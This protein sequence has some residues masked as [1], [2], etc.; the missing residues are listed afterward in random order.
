MESK[1]KSL[2]VTGMTVIA[3]LAT[4]VPAQALS[5]QSFFTNPIG[6]YVTL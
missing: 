6:K 4:A 1:F 2:V 5:I 3:A